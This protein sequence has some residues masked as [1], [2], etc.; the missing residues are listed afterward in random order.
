[1]PDGYNPDIH[2][3]DDCK[4]VVH[5]RE[6]LGAILADECHGPADSE[7]ERPR[8]FAADYVQAFRCHE[9]PQSASL[10]LTRTRKFNR[11]RI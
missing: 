3:L 4:R 11:P 10:W 6:Q 2:V 9:W 8:T 7:L 5:I 1:M